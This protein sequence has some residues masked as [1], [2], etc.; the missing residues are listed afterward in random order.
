MA[1]TCLN[2]LGW[3]PDAIQ[4]QMAHAER[5]KVRAAYNRAERLA[6]RRKMM[7]AWADYLDR[8]RVGRAEI[9]ATD[10]APSEPSNDPVDE[11]RKRTKPHGVPTAQLALSLD[12][13]S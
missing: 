9:V 4:L 3:H 13:R 8:L 5:N 2:E 11:S 10:A 6:E 12:V 1:C 7:Q